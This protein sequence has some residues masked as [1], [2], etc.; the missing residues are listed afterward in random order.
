M[1]GSSW[2]ATRRAAAAPA[3]LTA[4]TALTP[5]T[6][7]T[8]LTLLTVLAVLAGAAACSSA[9]PP[10]P[11]R[12][13]VPK[14]ADLTASVRAAPL[15]HWTGSWRA[16]VTTRELAP[17][18]KP[19]EDV[20]ADLTALDDGIL[21]GTLTVAGAPASVLVLGEQAVFVKAKAAYWRK[22][23]HV[24]VP[25][26]DLTG[27]W[28]LH[29][30]PVQYG[31]DLMRLTPRRVA[32]DLAAVTAPVAT[33]TGAPPAPSVP[34]WQDPPTAVPL[35]YPPPDGAPATAARMDL[36]RMD[37]SGTG[38]VRNGAYWFSAA[39][40]YRLLGYSGAELLT[41]P[42]SQR[43]TARLTARPGTAEE[44]A[45]AYDELRELLREVP[46]TVTANAFAHLDTELSKLT[47]CAPGVCGPVAVGV[48]LRNDSESFTV[49]EDLTVTLYGGGFWQ[50]ER[51]TGKVG[52]CRVSVRRL[53]P[54][55]S[56]RKVCTVQDPRIQRMQRKEKYVWFRGS[57]SG[58]LTEV[59]A[60]S[61]AERLARE[62]PRS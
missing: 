35:A 40:P 10:G 62:L 18:I 52:E 36:V 42:S 58:D 31:L 16:S 5:L 39:A 19:T 54:G 33:G 12:P 6:P 13:D 45:A 44:A 25:A 15:L 8:A 50:P 60:P 47:P 23:E 2:K 11:A 61:E 9:P 7:L 4:L 55:K 41:A 24:D 37:G 56:V 51:I 32:A 3:G 20:T 27:T 21:Y 43:D 48:R 26:G 34:S 38:S 28:V 57:V 46:R 1:T 22:M 14:A 17:G 59:T 49:S 30:R 29:R 53:A